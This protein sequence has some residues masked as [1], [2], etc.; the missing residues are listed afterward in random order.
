MGARL[1]V[2]NLSSN[3]TEADLGGVFSEEGREV[4]QVKV[5]TDRETGHPRGFA[6][7]QL[8]GD[9][10]A[11]QAMDALNGREVQGSEITVKEARERSGGGDR[12]RRRW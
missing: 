1:F 9:S 5:V 6:F 2:G 11:K 8:A 10:A 12:S 3:T 7:V 4:K